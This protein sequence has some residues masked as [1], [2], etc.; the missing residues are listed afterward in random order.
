[1]TKLKL[2]ILNMTK[3]PRCTIILVHA[4][5]DSRFRRYDHTTKYGLDSSWLIIVFNALRKI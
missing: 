2:K 3:R 4:A 5:T 1:M